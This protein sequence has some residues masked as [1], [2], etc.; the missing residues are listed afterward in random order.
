MLAKVQGGDPIAESA[1]SST[2]AR[3]TRRPTACCAWSSRL[4]GET[5]TDCRLIIGYLHTGIEKNA[6][7]RTWT[8]GVTFVTR[9]DYLAPLFNETR[10]LPGGRAAARHDGPD[11]GAVDPA[12][13][14]GDQPRLLA[15]GVALATGGMEIGALTAMTN[16]FREREA[17]P[18]RVR[19][20]HRPAHEPRASSVPAASPRTCP[21]GVEKHP[22]VCDVDD[23]QGD[24][25]LR[26]RCCTGQPIWQQPPQGVG[27]LGVDGCLALGVTGP[28]LRAAGLAWDL[29]K[30]DPYLG[31]EQY[32][33]EVPT[34]DD[35]DCVALPGAGRGDARVAADHRAVRRGRLEPGPVMVDDAEDRVAG[36]A[37]DRRG[38]HGQLA[39]PRPQDHGHVDGVAD[40]PL[41]ARDRGLQGPAG[42]GLRRRSSRRAASSAPTWSPTAAP[43]RSACTCASPASSTCRSRPRCAI[44]GMV[45]DVIAALAASTR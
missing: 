3:S 2:W 44:G 11:A 38:R 29:R 14:D 28:I 24:R 1:S 22:R 34:D 18:G 17:V 7:Y 33:F 19:A 4:E 26:P 16:G 45:S 43:A 23:P 10:V 27:W 40:P 9:C 32:D 36:Q 15:P 31:Y 39:R 25:R 37:L 12:D 30:T 8:Q 35:G 42:P 21:T 41:Q 6:E 13:P 5:V 20:H